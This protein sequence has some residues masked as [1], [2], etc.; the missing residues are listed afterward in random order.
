MPTL[1]ITID[2]PPIEGGISTLARQLAEDL[3]RAGE[4]VIVVAP[5]VRRESFRSDSGSI[6]V[7]RFPFYRAGYLRFFPCA[8][9]PP[10]CFSG[11]ESEKWSR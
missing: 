11:T 7:Y 6:R 1:L 8:S 9:F 5:R 3:A 2:Y 10:G 4:E